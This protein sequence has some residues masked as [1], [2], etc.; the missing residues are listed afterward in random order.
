[1]SFQ[2]GSKVQVISSESQPQLVGEITTI[3]AI[4]DWYVHPYETDLGVDEDGGWCFLAQDLKLID[5]SNEVT[6]WSK[7]AFQPKEL[8]VTT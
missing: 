2:I 5:D 3:I 1:M 6:E 8:V 4:H 7:C